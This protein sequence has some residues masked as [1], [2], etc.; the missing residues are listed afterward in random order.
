MQFQIGEYV[1]G[2]R[3]WFRRSPPSRT[4]PR[5]EFVGEQ[6]GEG[7]RRL[8]AELLPL[9]AQYAEI[10]RAYLARIG[11]QPGDASSVALCLITRHGDN[12]ALVRRIDEVFKRLVPANVFLDVA[13]LT[14]LQE[15]DVNRVC[16][17]FYHRATGDVHHNSD[18][19]D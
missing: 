18:A 4:E 8:K 1:M 19:D 2:F 9:L 3:D 17:P 6:D 14:A 7:E 13:F 16:R 12:Q 5:I 15:E 11:F 10:E